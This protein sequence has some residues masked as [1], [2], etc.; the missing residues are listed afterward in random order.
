M[1][2]AAPQFLALGYADGSVQVL[3]LLDLTVCFLW[4]PQTHSFPITGLAVDESGKLLYSVSA[5]GVL[6]CNRLWR[7]GKK[8]LNYTALSLKAAVIAVLV[9]LVVGLISL[10]PTPQNPV[11]E[12]AEFDSFYTALA[13]SD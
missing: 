4:L 5:D 7:R 1:H 10:Q 3:S 11:D 2:V 9:A 8:P 6:K 12:Q 13:T